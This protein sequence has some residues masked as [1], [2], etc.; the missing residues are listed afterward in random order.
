MC[1]IFLIHV[2]FTANRDGYGDMPKC[3]LSTGSFSY[4]EIKI[5]CYL[6]EKKALIIFFRFDL[7]IYLCM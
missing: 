5:S 7:K 4:Q 1:E 3:E 2:V 6:F